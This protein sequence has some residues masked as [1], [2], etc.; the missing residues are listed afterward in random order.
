MKWS[1]SIHSVLCDIRMILNP[2]R[3]K[4]NVFT[5]PIYDLSVAE[6]GCATQRDKCDRKNEII[7]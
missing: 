7:P 3:R 2:L 5:I 1:H 4:R 6:R